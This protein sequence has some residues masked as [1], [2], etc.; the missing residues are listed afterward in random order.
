MLQK[1]SPETCTK[2]S[3]FLSSN[4]PLVLSVVEV[5][6]TQYCNYLL[7][8][9]KFLNSPVFPSLD[10]YVISR[11]RLCVL[12]TEVVFFLVYFNSMWHSEILLCDYS[13][14]VLI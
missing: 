7:S 9:G 11:F 10:S 5:S 1:T 3:Y 4:L 12:G 13:C 8:C 14:C 6:P 2:L